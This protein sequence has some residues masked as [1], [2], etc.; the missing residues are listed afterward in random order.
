LRFDMEVS[1]AEKSPA[2][3]SVLLDLIVS[4]RKTVEMVEP[5]LG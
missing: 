2:C 5:K 3:F 1:F 4:R